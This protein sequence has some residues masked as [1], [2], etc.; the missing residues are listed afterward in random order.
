MRLS[1]RLS[2][3]ENAPRVELGGAAA[4]LD[5]RTVRFKLSKRQIYAILTIILV[6]AA[7][8]RLWA[9][10]TVPPALFLDE[11]ADGAN[12][13]QAWETGDFKVFY[14]EDHGRE[15]L[16]I[17]VASVFI[18]FLGCK[19]WPLRLPAAIFGILTVAGI[20]ALT[21][22][23]IS[24]PAGLAAAFF[25]AT[26]Y[27]HLNFSRIAF[28][29]IGAPLFLVWALYLLLLAFRRLRAGRE[30]AVLAVFA[31]LIYGAGFYTYI[32]Y[33]IT[34]VLVILVL[35]FLFAEA[36]QGGWMQGYCITSGL[37]AIVAA[38]A[39][40]P[41]AAYSLSHQAM[42]TARTTKL[43]VFQS[44][45]P[46]Y[47]IAKNIWKTVGM[48]Y[49]KGDSIWRHNYAGRPEVFWPVAL[50]MTLGTAVAIRKIF[51]RSSPAILLPPVLLIVWIALGAVPA[52]L[53]N[54]AVPHALRSILMLPPVAILAA[55]GVTESFSAV[56]RSIPTAILTIA[57]IAF[58]GT[59]VAETSHEY[60]DLWAKDPR[61]PEWFDG[62]NA[63][64]AARINSLPREKAKVVA[65][66]GPSKAADSFFLPLISL[67][68]LTK[69]VTL[70]QQSESNIRYYTPLT[71]PF[72]LPPDPE[73]GDFCAK[74]QAAMPEAVVVCLG[75]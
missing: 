3:S 10:T 53:S 24:Q 72:P 41:L 42:V 43:S 54:D 17:N 22:E 55:I 33:R 57:V 62:K 2:T 19:A 7:G 75:M 45:N 39:V 52:V 38:A 31:G 47:L 68:F 11:A 65:I 50:L 15:G 59:L 6:I 49:W 58:A 21:A 35:G 60:F 20:Y 44:S 67:R 51:A 40:Y 18:H 48:L 5:P 71:F 1:H 9:I 23:L 27:W 37:F 36:V 26:S 25:L 12:A 13:V 46:A 34:P 16:Y 29:G 30:S 66:E 28:R 73:A 61:T 74:V 64:V 14:P 8:L 4:T 32:A 69:S 63:L 56:P 70:K